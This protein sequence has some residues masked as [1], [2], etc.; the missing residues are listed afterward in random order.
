[1][2]EQQFSRFDSQRLI[3]NREMRIF[4]SSTFSDMDAERTALIKTFDTLKIE[5]NQRNVTLSVVDLRWGVTEE[6]ARSGKVLSVCFEEIE[7]SH[8]FFIGL[9]GSRYGTSPSL[10][11]LEKNP[12]L[13][14]RYPWIRKDIEDGMSITEMEIQYGILRN[15]HDVDAAFF[16]KATPGTVPDDNEKLKCLKSKI[17]KQKH[18]L[19][20]V[21]T[22]IEDLCA[23]VEVAIRKILNKNFPECELSSLERER[24]VQKAYINTRHGYYQR[25]QADFDRLDAFLNNDGTHLVITGPSGIGKSSLIANWLKEKQKEDLNYN[26][27]YHFVGNSFSGSDYRQILQHLCDEIYDIYNLERTEEDNSLEQ[28]VQRILLEAGHKGKPLFIVIDGINQIMDY[29]DSKM[30]S[31]LPQ[32]PLTTK[33]LFSTLEGDA[34]MASFRRLGYPEHSIKTPDRFLRK[35]FLVNYLHGVGKKLTQ[36]QIDRI[37]DDSKNENMLV[38][39]TLLDELICFGSHKLLDNRIDYYL[40]ATSVENFFDRLLQRIE[41]D[42]QEVPRILSLIALSYNGLKEDELQAISC[43]RPMDFRQLNSALYNHLILRDGLTT[44]AHQYINDAVCCRY[45]LDD[46]NQANPYRHQIINYILN[47]N[48]VI[49]EREL[50]E[51]AFQYYHIDNDEMLYKTILNLEAFKYFNSSEQNKAFLARY[52]H[53]LLKF[54]SEKYQLRDYLDLPSKIGSPD[55]YLKIGDFVKEYMADPKTAML[56]YQKFQ[57]TARDFFFGEAKPSLAIYYI[58]IGACCDDLGNYIESLKYYFMALNILEQHPEMRLHLIR[59][60]NNIGEVY[61]QQSNFKEAIKYYERAL[62]TFQ[63]NDAIDDLEIV[64]V[65][66]VYNNMGLVFFELGKYQQALESYGK[67]LTNY[68]KSIKP[69][70]LFIASVHNNLGQTYDRLFDHSMSLEHYMKSLNIFEKLFGENHPKSATLYSNIAFSYINQGLYSDALKYQEKDLYICERVLG[71]DHPSIIMTYLNMGYILLKKGE[72]TRAHEY[73]NR[74]LSLCLKHFGDN[75]PTTATCYNYLG[76]LYRELRDYAEAL[77]YY[78]KSFE[79]YSTV[80]GAEHHSTAT[81]IY[82]IGHIYAVMGDFIESCNYLSMAYNIFLKLFGPNHHYTLIV[83]KLLADV[84]SRLP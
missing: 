25:V 34:T 41:E 84:K 27:I 65:A 46:S 31:W 64:S 68:E 62:S 71:N 76:D 16:I 82:N 37:L 72:M 59:L 1:M 32:A 80:Y 50:F 45:G 75:N 7:H 21:Y 44:F 18:I 22:S 51:L 47:N 3:D 61:R 15:S 30:L 43:L 9:L 57:A 53:K 63:S 79:V 83:Y 5:A 48:S 77:N 24:I 12:E 26:I 38:L 52:W 56:Y 28:E 33:Y 42:Y 67:A 49:R 55:L 74:S 69:D 78:R 39:K 60:Y 23:K 19:K 2:D 66:T 17:Q 29:D 13:E 14:E 70:Q 35:S 6:E 11:E 81:T 10:S 73:F 4:L 36:Q 58:Q 40:S 20:E 54:S 8:P